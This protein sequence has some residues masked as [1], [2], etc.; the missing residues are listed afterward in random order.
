[1]R[2]PTMA[3]N[4]INSV[5]RNVKDKKVTN[6][7]SLA[8]TKVYTVTQLM[9]EAVRIELLRVPTQTEKNRI[10]RIKNKRRFEVYTGTAETGTEI[11]SRIGQLNN[12]EVVVPSDGLDDEIFLYFINLHNQLRQLFSTGSCSELTIW[13]PMCIGVARTI[14]Y[15]KGVVDR[16]EMSRDPK[17][18]AITL[19]V[20]EIKTFFNTLKPNELFPDSLSH[21]SIFRHEL[22]VNIYRLMISTLF[23]WIFSANGSFESESMKML[24]FTQR[25]GDMTVPAKFYNLLDVDDDELDVYNDGAVE[26]Q[27]IAFRELLSFIKGRLLFYAKIVSPVMPSFT[28]H[29]IYINQQMAADIVTMYDEVGQKDTWRTYNI[30]GRRTLAYKTDIW[31]ERR[32]TE[33]YTSLSTD[34]KML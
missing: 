6:V 13:L 32:L 9:T 3:I 4:K 21:V 15:V 19:D 23:K 30:N 7:F 11:H 5:C 24:F 17:T 14:V 31:V 8:N 33:I 29:L 26:D 18:N 1:M 22:Q 2:Y 10:K 34:D 25:N 20:Q 16:I 28:S 27:K 12:E